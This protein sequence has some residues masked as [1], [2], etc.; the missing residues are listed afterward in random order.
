ME[1]R[2]FFTKSPR[3]STNQDDTSNDAGPDRSG[4]EW[5]FRSMSWERYLLSAYRNRLGM[6]VLRGGED[7]WSH[8][9]S[10][11]VNGNQSNMRGSGRLNKAWVGGE[12]GAMRTSCLLR[13]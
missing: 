7:M 4:V 5:K 3:K 11:T 1:F 2:F 8:Y 10:L 13:A 12:K 9:S 6:A